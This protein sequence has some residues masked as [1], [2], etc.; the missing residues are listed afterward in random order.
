MHL[1][2]SS[3]SSATSND[4]LSPVTPCQPL[5]RACHKPVS[6]SAFLTP[7]SATLLPVPPGP[8]TC[9]T[10]TGCPGHWWPHPT[11]VRLLHASVCLIMKTFNLIYFNL[12]VSCNCFISRAV[13]WEPQ[14][15]QAK[16]GWHPCKPRLPL[17]LH[18]PGQPGLFPYS[19]DVAL[20]RAPAQAAFG[21]LAAHLLRGQG[22]RHSA[23]LPATKRAAARYQ[24]GRRCF[25][26]EA[27]ALSKHGRHA[28]PPTPWQGRGVSRLPSTKMAAPVRTRAGPVRSG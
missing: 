14:P 9:H 23:V 8:A 27:G 22:S 24:D 2:C 3:R 26:S 19:N 15:G 12:N 13:V 4:A 28:G 18:Q 7:S 11:G 1:C 25:H 5:W 21:S 6:P 20:R 16:P 10:C 17:R